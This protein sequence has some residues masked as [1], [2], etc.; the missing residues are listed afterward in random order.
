MDAKCYAKDL[1]GNRDPV[2][3]EVESF[4][5]RSF[6]NRD[7]DLQKVEQAEKLIKKALEQLELLPER[8]RK[9]YARKIGL[10]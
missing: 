3:V 10:K 4:L 8:Y 5:Y 2:Q 6:Q 1:Y 9:F 7:F